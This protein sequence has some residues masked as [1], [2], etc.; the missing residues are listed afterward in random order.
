[1]PESESEMKDKTRILAETKAYA[2]LD[3]GKCTAACSVAH[4]DPGFSPRMLVYDAIHGTD[5]QALNDDRLWE[6]LTCA[7]CEVVCTSAVR[8]GD[9]IRALRSQAQQSGITGQCAHGGAIQSLMHIMSAEELQQDRL[10]WVP[11][12]LEVAKTSDTLYFVGCAPYFDAFFADLEVKTLQASLGSI[13]L[14]NRMGIR[15][16]VSPNERCCGHDLL[17][18]G[19][20]EGFLK[21]ARQN[22]KEIQATGAKRVVVSCPEGYHTLKVEYPRYLGDTGFEVVHL[23]QLLAEAVANG[24]L[25]FKKSK[26]KVTYHD[27]C[28]LGR[29]SGIY[30]EPRM[31][32]RAIEGLQLQEMAH[33]KAHALC[34]GTQ[35]WMNCGTI[36]KQMQ[37]E[38]LKEAKTTG[39]DT[40]IVACPKSQIHLKCAMHDEG[41]G[42]QLQIKIQDFAGFVAGKLAGQEVNP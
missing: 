18:S 5:S 23:S 13:A 11:R 28:R 7:A 26:K 31:V 14:L 33:H 20:V 38:L 36:N 25:E 35:S 12:Q 16:A 40:L 10:D 34:C 29:I 27:S 19:D 39:A 8:F 37:I 21:L 2:C 30:E 9:F 42:Q 32:L 1:M 4:H 3:C 15:P 22:V 41:P 17:N 24:Q 6:C